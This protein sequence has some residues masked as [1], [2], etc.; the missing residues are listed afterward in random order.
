MFKPNIGK[1]FLVLNPRKIY[2]PISLDYV[3]NVGTGFR[4]GFAT[5][6]FLVLTADEFL[7]SR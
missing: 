3:G 2:L 5:S 7:C 4:P 1:Q 6:I